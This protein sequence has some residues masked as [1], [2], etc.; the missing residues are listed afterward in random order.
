[1][2]GYGVETDFYGSFAPAAKAMMEGKM[3]LDASYGPGYHLVLILFYSIFNDMFEVGK[4][5]SILSAVLLF[6]F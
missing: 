6:Y 3:E 1:M 4:F 5:V 2:G